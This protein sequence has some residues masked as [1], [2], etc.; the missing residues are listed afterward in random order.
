[1]RRPSFGADWG[2]YIS[3]AERLRERADN[4]GVDLLLID[5]G[6][7]IDGNGLY[8]ASDPKGLYTSE[9]FKEQDI[10]IICSGN[11]ELYRQVASET[12]FLTT[13]PNYKGNYLASNIDIFD[14]KSEDRVPLAPRFKKFTTKNQGIRVLA[15][16]FIFDFT[17]NANNTI[18]QP[19]RETIKE[20]W[21]QEAIRD[22]DVDLFLVAGHVPLRSEEFN[23]I[24]KTIREVQWDTPIQFFGGHTH[25]RDY[26][27]YDSKAFA[28]ES[29]RYMET[30]GFM[31]ITGLATGG[32]RNELISD[33]LKGSKTMGPLASPEFA[34]RYIDNNLFSYYHHTSLNSTSFPTSHGQNVSAMISSARKALNLDSRFGC[35]PL[36]LWTNRAPYPSK[37][38]IF[39]WLQESVFPDMIHDADRE[40]KSTLVLTNTGALRFDIFQGAFT[41]DTTYSVSPFDNSFRYIADVPFNVAKQLLLVLNSEVPQLGGATPALR[42]KLPV[43]FER[44]AF[45]QETSN[46]KAPLAGVIQHQTVLGDDDPNLSPGYTTVD[47]AGADGDDTVHSP[48]KFYRVPNFI[49]SRI[50]FSSTASKRPKLTDVTQQSEDPDVVDLVFIDFVQEYILLALKFFGADYSEADTNLYMGGVTMTRLIGKW[51]KENWNGEC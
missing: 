33:A 9:I 27:K 44:L 8:D 32:K 37:D 30:I 40:D 19:V 51:V 38:S 42:A 1:M 12:E 31:S 13:V 10:D 25:V 35:A 14:P 6:D 7:R 29:G 20:K 47:D 17:G 41:I 23:S 45:H 15:F 49:E 4:E 43:P 36:D 11:H 22:R 39:T 46:F 16:G 50:G 34:R 5:T 3:F 21:F 24:F 18:V 48:I 2:D 28:L 26:S